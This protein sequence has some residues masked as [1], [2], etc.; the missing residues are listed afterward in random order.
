MKYI[1]LLLLFLLG[2]FGFS[3]ISESTVYFFNRDENKYG[4]SLRCEYISYY[5][6]SIPFYKNIDL[7][8]ENGKANVKFKLDSS[9]IFSLN[10]GPKVLAFILEPNITLKIEGDEVLDV[11]GSISNKHSIRYLSNEYYFQRPFD[12]GKT[13]LQY[14]SSD[15]MIYFFEYEL[16]TQIRKP[17]N[18]LLKAKKIDSVHHRELI[19][20]LEISWVSSMLWNIEIKKANKNQSQFLKY[21][22]QTYDPFDKKYNNVPG[23]IRLIQIRRKALLISN[24][25]M[26]GGRYDVGLWPERDN[27]FNFVPIYLQPMIAYEQMISYHDD[28][29]YDYDYTKI[30]WGNFQKLHP[31]HPGLPKLRK[32]FSGLESAN[33][34]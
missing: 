26:E 15:K 12:I 1:L 24:N 10:F 31:Q 9:L 5:N 16:D 28:K 7:K 30:I 2:N 22:F 14:T 4:K 25:I 23:S 6:D 27:V 20:I 29:K 32:V 33:K 11:K 19:K 17:L 21:L 34:K 8:F 3:Q 18:Q 13:L